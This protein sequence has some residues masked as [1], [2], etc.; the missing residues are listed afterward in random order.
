MLHVDSV[1]FTKL[2]FITFQLFSDMYDLYSSGQYVSKGESIIFM[3]GFCLCTLSLDSCQVKTYFFLEEE[4][5]GC[6]NSVQ[7]V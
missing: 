7:I 2:N 5:V 1:F 3:L 6:F 4:R